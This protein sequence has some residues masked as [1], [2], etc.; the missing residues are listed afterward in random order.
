MYAT[1]LEDFETEMELSNGSDKQIMMDLKP[2]SN[3]FFTIG[4]SWNTGQSNRLY[5]EGGYAVALTNDYYEVKNGDI[6]SDDSEA[7]M[8]ILRPGGIIIAFGFEFGY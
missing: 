8:G 3:I 1:G 7:V 5:L 6:L 2:V 4:H